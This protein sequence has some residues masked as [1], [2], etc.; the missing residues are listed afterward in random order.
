MKKI[1]DWSCGAGARCLAG[2]GGGGQDESGGRKTEATRPA[3]GGAGRADEAN[4]GTVTGKVAFAGDKPK[5]KNLDMSAT[6][7]LRARAYHAAEIARK[8]WSMATER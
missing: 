7:G 2:C 8:W 1:L 5:M 3:A 6:P 4:G